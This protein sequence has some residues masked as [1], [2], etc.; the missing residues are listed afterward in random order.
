[1]DIFKKIK[2]LNLPLGKYAV[3]SGA[4]LSARG[5]RDA[6]DIDI[7]VSPDVFRAL[8]ESGKFKEKLFSDGTISL[9]KDCYEIS[10]KFTVSGKDLVP[11]DVIKNADIIGGF[12][13][14]NLRDELIFKTT[15]GR[16]KDIKDVELIKKYLL[17]NK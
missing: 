17:G 3:I 5:I 7:I 13:F 10:D 9:S 8:K 11:L 2:E 6:Y 15:F 16:E 14:S 1:M 4:S 12:P